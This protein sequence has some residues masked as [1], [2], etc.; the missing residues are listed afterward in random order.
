MAAKLRKD[1]EVIVNAG[2]DKGKTGKIL[3]VLD[4]DYVIV[5]GVNI[6]KKHVKAN[7]NAGIEGGIVEFEAKIHVSNLSYLDSNTSKGVRIGFKF[8]GD[9]KRRYNKVSGEF[10]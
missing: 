5:E 7:P 8:D 3:R 10:I 4:K 9:K 2:R 6:A 1:D